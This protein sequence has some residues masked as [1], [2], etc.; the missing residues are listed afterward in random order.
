MIDFRK[1]NTIYNK[2]V[3]VLKQVQLKNGGCLATPKGERYPYIYPRDHAMIIL[4]FLSANLTKRAK[5]GLDFILGCQSESGAFPQRIDTEGN[6]ASYK[7]VQID[8]T[9]LVLHAFSEYI[10]HVQDFGFAK[11]YWENI[12]RAVKYIISRNMGKLRVLCCSQEDV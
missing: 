7:P 8:G 6:D 4:G 11:D 1:A 10:R 2:S 3:G 9:G 12:R 5:K